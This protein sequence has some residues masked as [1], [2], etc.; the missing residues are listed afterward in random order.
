[1]VFPP[2]IFPLRSVVVK[3][4][5]TPKISGPLLPNSF[6]KVSV[7]EFIAVFENY[8]LIY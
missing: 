8:I 3:P 7:K 4:G 2:G 5:V 1:M 6:P